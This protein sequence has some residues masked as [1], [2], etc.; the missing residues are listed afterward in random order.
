MLPFVKLLFTAFAY[1]ITNFLYITAVLM[2]FV[3][4]KRNAGLEEE[5]LGFSRDSTKNMLLSSMLGGMLAGLGL[6]FLITG[7]GIVVDMNAL[8]LIWGLAM[9]FMLATNRGMGF[10]YAA[11]IVSLSNLI[12]G[13]PD[14]DPASI[15]ALTG[16][17]YLAESLLTMTDGS[18]G[19]L[20]VVVRHKRYSPA[21]AYVSNKLWPVPLVMLVPSLPGQAGSGGISM[22]EWWPLLSGGSTTGAFGLIYM[23]ALLCYQDMAV[24]APAKQRTRD[25]GFFLCAYSLVVLILAVAADALYVMKYAAAL[26]TPV[27]YWLVTFLLRRGIELG[28][29]IYTPP[30]RGLRVLAIYPESPGSSMGIR[31]GDILLNLNGKAIN[32]EEMLK[33]ELNGSPTYIWIDI[34]RNGS[35]MTLD[36]RDYRNGIAD[37]GLVFVPRKTGHYYSFGGNDKKNTLFRKLLSGRGKAYRE[38]SDSSSLFTRLF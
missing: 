25:A 31:P 30:W 27:L 7:L 29:P 16:I 9:L 34:S 10:A 6:S 24:T 23:A 14:T 4:V 13:W 36:H 3:N 2:A 28:T 19:A 18:S 20:P 33:T 35:K 21:G 32:S 12:L 11:G 17:L 26:L 15:T 1:S 22:P 5:W 38:W 37:I 8:M